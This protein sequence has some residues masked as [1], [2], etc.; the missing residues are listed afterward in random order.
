ME[1][2]VLKIFRFLRLA[3]GN[4]LYSLYSSRS[5]LSLYKPST[6]LKLGSEISFILESDVTLIKSNYFVYL[7]SIT[8]M[9]RSSKGV[10]L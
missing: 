1:I 5:F 2:K 4:S 7:F 3:G 6:K 9:P 10:S 8:Y